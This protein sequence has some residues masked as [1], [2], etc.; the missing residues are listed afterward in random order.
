[1]NVTYSQCVPVAL[2]IHHA[3][4]MCRIAICCP[5]PLYNISPHYLINSTI[6]GMKLLNKKRVF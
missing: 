4:R 5:V 1:M 2:G 3:I 6:W